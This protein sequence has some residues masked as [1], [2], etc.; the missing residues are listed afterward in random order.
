[1]RGS[2]SKQLK[3]FVAY[4]PVQAIGTGQSADVSEVLEMHAFLKAVLVERFPEVAS[5]AFRVLYG[6]S[7]D[8]ENAYALLRETVVDGVLV[9]SAS[10]KLNS[11]AEIVQAASEV[12]E[13]QS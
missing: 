9:G 10:V 12:L 3:T 1:L 5:G 4:E 13:A 11:F 2:D 8:G 7:V 6:G